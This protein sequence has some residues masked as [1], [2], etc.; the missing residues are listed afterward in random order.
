[1]HALKGLE[2]IFRKNRAPWLY[3]VTQWDFKL[4]GRYVR[5]IT[6]LKYIGTVFF[7]PENYGFSSLFETLFCHKTMHME[8]SLNLQVF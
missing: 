7:V 3:T 8:T 1:M 5:Q 6:P 4:S 2:E